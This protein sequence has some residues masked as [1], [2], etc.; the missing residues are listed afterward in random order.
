M[1]DAILRACE[2]YGDKENFAAAQQ[3]AMNGDYSWDK[4]AKIYEALYREILYYSPN[5]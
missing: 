2:L 4:S 1:K 5:S 3:N